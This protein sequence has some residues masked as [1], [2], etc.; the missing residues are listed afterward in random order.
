MMTRLVFGEKV[1]VL[2]VIK[3]ILDNYPFSV[4]IFREL[5]Q[6]S[7][8]A[9]A[10]EQ[11]RSIARSIIDSTH[12]LPSSQVFVLDCRTHSSKKLLDPSF[13]ELQGPALLAFNEAQFLPEDWEALQN[14]SE[15]SKKED[16]SKS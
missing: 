1:S 3:S 11:V 15:S 4:G 6:N 10:Q 5:L 9:K 12:S 16:T 8:D 14:I 2:G 7:D 13:S